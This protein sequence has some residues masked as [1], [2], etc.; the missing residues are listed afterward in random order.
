M[1]MK[2]SYSLYSLEKQEYYCLENKIILFMW[3]QI[4]QIEKMIEY[5]L[6]NNLLWTK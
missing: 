4:E 2:Y 1:K 5:L 3:S 6:D